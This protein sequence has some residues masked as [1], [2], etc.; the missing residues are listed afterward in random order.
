MQATF[1]FEAFPPKF[2]FKI[3]ADVVVISTL[4]QDHVRHAL[5]AI[6][7]GYDILLEKPITCE[8]KELYEL[9][10]AANAKNVKILV[11]HVLRY[12]VTME[13]IKERN[14]IIQE[15][16]GI[17]KD[18]MVFANDLSLEVPNDIDDLPGIDILDVGEKYHWHKRKVLDKLE[19]QAEEEGA[20]ALI[21]IKVHNF[22]GSMNNLWI[23]RYTI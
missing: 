16:M 13:K 5:M 23:N 18:R 19:K 20:N 7:L 21:G 4:D 22:C 9:Q 8:E 3:G 17:L 1:P 15:L 12:T 2:K 10:K 11:C 6:K 14:F